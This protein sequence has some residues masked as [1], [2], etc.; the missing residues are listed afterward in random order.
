[1]WQELTNTYTRPIPSALG[2]ARLIPS[3]ETCER[4]HW[5]EKIVATRLLVV[6]SYAP[7]EANSDSYSVLM[8]LV[9][10]SAMQG[11][12][13]AHF[14]GGFEIR[15]AASDPE[16]QTIPWV[17]RRNLRTGETQTYLADGTKPEQAAV[18]PQHTMQCVD[19][20]DRPTHAF[21]L[22]DRALNRALALGAVPATLPFIKKQSL[23]VL[24]AT[25]SADA[26]QKIPA[27]SRRERHHHPGLRRMPPAACGAGPVP[28]H[29]EDVGAVGPHRSVEGALSGR[30]FNI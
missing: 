30:T 21:W 12:H 28:G 18:L 5:A 25:S 26:A 22:P 27:A 19:C 17:E 4:C 6:P 8:M 10:G 2:S 15:Y 29:S 20:H 16:R 24:Q 13:H 9:G 1:M 14:A 3:R 11:I 7:D 23:V